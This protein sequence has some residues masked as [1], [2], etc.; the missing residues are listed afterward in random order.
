MHVIKHALIYPV[1]TG[2][3]AKVVSCSWMENAKVHLNDMH[4][5]V[6]IQYKINKWF[7]IRKHILKAKC[8][9]IVF[10]ACNVFRMS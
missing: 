8:F 5:T 9:E 6:C 2:V 3:N 7:K 1:I 10:M 4:I